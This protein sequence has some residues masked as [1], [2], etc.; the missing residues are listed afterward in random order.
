MPSDGSSTGPTPTITPFSGVQ[1]HVTYRTPVS[2]RF[3]AEGESGRVD[4]RA[5]DLSADAQVR[6]PR[7]GGPG[8]GVTAHSGAVPAV[9]GHEHGGGVGA[10]LGGAA[11]RGWRRRILYRQRG[12]QQASSSAAGWRLVT[13]A[14]LVKTSGS[15][16]TRWWS[17]STTTNKAGSSGRAS[18]ANRLVPR[19]RPTS[20]LAIG[21]LQPIPQL[22]PWTPLRHASLETQGLL[23]RAAGRADDRASRPLFARPTA[24]TGVTHGAAFWTT[25]NSA[26]SLRAGDC[27]VCDCGGPRHRDHP[28]TKAGNIV[29]PRSRGSAVP[30]PP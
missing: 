2:P 27:F 23:A 24:G 29:P 16:T 3:G 12:K 1:E 19:G 4:P 28:T 14:G 25:G 18:R 21:R 5:A 17:C 6:H 13:N 22:T 11:L 20:D 26:G 7:R 10:G 8:R 9:S 30:R 15:S